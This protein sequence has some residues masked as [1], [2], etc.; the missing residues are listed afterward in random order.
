M[1]GATVH[2]RL[3]AMCNMQ[4]KGISLLGFFASTWYWLHENQ[5]S[6]VGGPGRT[7]S[8]AHFP[9]HECQLLALT[10]S[11]LATHRLTRRR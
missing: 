11:L 10:R 8:A 3:A 4:D 6:V 5:V 7:A 9:V 1:L 2:Y